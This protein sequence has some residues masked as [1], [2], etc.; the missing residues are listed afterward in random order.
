MKIICPGHNGLIDVPH[1]EMLNSLNSPVKGFIF[2]CPICEDE[3]LI[4]NIQTDVSKSKLS[5]KSNLVSNK[6]R[7][8]ELSMG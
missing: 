4:T 1:Q 6:N 5:N 3:V 7:V 8:S 2:N